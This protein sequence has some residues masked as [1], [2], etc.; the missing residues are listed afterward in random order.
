MASRKD[1]NVPDIG[2]FENV[3]IVEVHVSA[4]DHV[5]LEDPLITLET[6]KA[7]MEVPATAAGVV[8]SVAVKQGDRVSQGDLVCSVE[9]GDEA[10]EEAKAEEQPTAAPTS[11]EP[12]KAAGQSVEVRVPDI[13][14]FSDVDVIDVHVSEGDN[15]KFDDP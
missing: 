1:I 10:A 9:T 5:A 13:G 3:E 4:G 12:G 2:D 7:S 14:D 8:A 15:V 11:A 6:D